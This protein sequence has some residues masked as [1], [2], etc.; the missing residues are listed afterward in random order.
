[1]LKAVR[2]KWQ[3]FCGGKTKK[4]GIFLIR[5]HEGQEEVAQDFS[6]IRWK[7]LSTQNSI[8]K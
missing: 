8:T 5:R 2:E 7:D 4:E 1:M 3:L 6:S